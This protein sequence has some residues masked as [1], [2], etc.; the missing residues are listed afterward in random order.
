MTFIHDDQ[1]FFRVAMELLGAGRHGVARAEPGE[2][3]F[4]F[5]L[6]PM[7]TEELGVWGRERLDEIAPRNP[8]AVMLQSMHTLFVNSAA[9]AAA[10]AL[11]CLGTHSTIDIELLIRS[12]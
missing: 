1:V 5:G 12:R 7:L 4:A 10:G 11:A 6:D 9:L 8:I 3:L 2:W